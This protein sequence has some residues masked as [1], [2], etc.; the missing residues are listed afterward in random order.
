MPHAAV[1]HA[2][3]SPSRDF[4]WARELV[5]PLS[6]QRREVAAFV[7][8]DPEW[9]LVGLRHHPSPAADAATI[10]V[11]DVVRDALAHDA[12]YVLM[13]HNHPSGDATP[14]RD[15]IAVTRRLARTLDAID[16]TLIDH[17]V[18]SANATTSFRQLGLL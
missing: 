11:R 2:A 9:R 17:L 7:Y 6:D 12:R 18:V 1:D 15:D 3:E 5:G 14:S 13:A 10:V 8:L 4:A 16:V